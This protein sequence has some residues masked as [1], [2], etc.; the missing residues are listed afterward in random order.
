MGN[1]CGGVSV[2]RLSRR[3]RSS[4]FLAGLAL[5]VLVAM[6]PAFAD[7]S[8]RGSDP[9]VALTVTPSDALSDAQVVTV[10]GTGFPPNTV[11]TLT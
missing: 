11:G 7:T 9:N 5:A 1:G 10:T 6:L 4:I 3:T 2:H 8:E